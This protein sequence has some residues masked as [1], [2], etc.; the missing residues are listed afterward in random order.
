MPGVP[1]FGG[2]HV[3]G[4]N[5][6]VSDE[7]PDVHDD[8]MWKQSDSPIPASWFLPV[9]TQSQADDSFGL[10]VDPLGQPVIIPPVYIDP[11]VWQHPNYEVI[12]HKALVAAR[13]GQFYN[14]DTHL[15]E[16]IS[17]QSAF[18]PYG[19]AATAIL[20]DG[21]M[22]VAVQMDSAN[23]DTPGFIRMWH[24]DK[25]L[26]VL[27][28][29]DE[30]WGTIVSVTGDPIPLAIAVKGNQVILTVTASYDEPSTTTLHSVLPVFDTP[31]GY[32]QD[33]P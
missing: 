28:T 12:A 31:D 10:P 11:L 26:T 4:P 29:H 18:Y 30:P 8:P 19:P 2:R 33:P 7:F 25:Y 14:Y 32:Q 24:L 6:S 13:N 21:T 9:P 15:Y 22:F 5:R 20:E 3:L 16:P 23:G 27:G 17:N 1:G